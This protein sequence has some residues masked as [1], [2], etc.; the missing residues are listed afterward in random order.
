MTKI[1]FKTEIP[2]KIKSLVSD[3]DWNNEFI[4][5]DMDCEHAPEAKEHVKVDCQKCQFD[6]RELWLEN[7]L[8]K[9]TGEETIK[10]KDNKIHKISKLIVIRGRYNDCIGVQTE[11]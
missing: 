1:I 6:K 8:D 11:Y 3:L 4:F 10:D 9:L 5:E 7:H 2:K